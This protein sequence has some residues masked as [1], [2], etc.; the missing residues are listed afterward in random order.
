M[1]EGILQFPGDAAALVERQQRIN[2]N[3]ISTRGGKIIYLLPPTFPHRRRPPKYG[4]VREISAQE[5]RNASGGAVTK[6]AINKS[7]PAK[8]NRRLWAITARA[9]PSAAAR[10]RRPPPA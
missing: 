5:Q 1:E 9:A 4:K 7:K 2:N 3:H 8:A 10:A 6:C